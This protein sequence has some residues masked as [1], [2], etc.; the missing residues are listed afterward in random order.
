MINSL[1]ILITLIGEANLKKAIL[2]IFTI[3]IAFI[4]CKTFEIKDKR[5]EGNIIFKKLVNE[6]KNL[7]STYITGLFKVTGS[8]EIPAGFIKFEANTDFKNLICVFKIKVLNKIAFDIFFEKENIFLVNNLKKCFLKF[9]LEQSDLAPIIG[10]NFNPIAISYIF[11][12]NIPYSDSLELSDFKTIKR[13]YQLSISDDKTNYIINLNKKL[14][15]VTIKINSQFYDSFLVTPIKYV[16]NENNEIVPQQLTFNQQNNNIKILFLIN[17]MQKNHKKEEIFNKDFLTNY[18]E[19]FS[20][21]ELDIK[22]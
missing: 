3:A 8:N 1:K 13:E 5:L 10:M 21:T 9:N 7:E 18:K 12:G 19:V 2:S 17:K 14:Q 20:I 4:G 16:T 11:S 22:K 15:F 6:A